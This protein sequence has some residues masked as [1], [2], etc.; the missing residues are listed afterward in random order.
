V[1]CFV[2]SRY[3]LYREV[4]VKGESIGLRVCS[5]VIEKLRLEGYND[6]AGSTIIFKI[7][8]WDNVWWQK[9]Y[10]A[11]RVLHCTTG[12]EVPAYII[13][14]DYLILT[15]RAMFGREEITLIRE[16]TFL[17]TPPPEKGLFQFLIL[18]FCSREVFSR[19]KSVTTIY[20][21]ASFHWTCQVHSISSHRALRTKHILTWA[22]FSKILLAF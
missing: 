9:Y 20:P 2:L 5:G 11:H 7:F 3:V 13:V 16:S 17:L 1:S 10:E 19:S 21:R 18:D 14:W 6:F 8:L 4:C 15:F 12:S 22:A